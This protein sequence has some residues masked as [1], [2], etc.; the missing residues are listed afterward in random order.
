LAEDTL[1]GSAHELSS[2]T[3]NAYLTLLNDLQRAVYL[4]KLRHGIDLLKE[5]GD[6]ASSNQK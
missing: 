1:Q 2:Y 4:L 3:N 5:E 6:D